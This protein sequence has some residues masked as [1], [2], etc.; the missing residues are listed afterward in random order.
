MSSSNVVKLSLPRTK[1]RQRQKPPE[2]SFYKNPG[3]NDELF[4]TIA[5]RVNEQT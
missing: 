5:S 3:N 1:A 2:S 4:E